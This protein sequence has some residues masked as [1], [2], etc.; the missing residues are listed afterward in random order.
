MWASTGQTT[1]GPA[2]K[3]LIRIPPNLVTNLLV[4][5][6][7]E[8]SRSVFSTKCHETIYCSVVG[9]VVVFPH[10]RIRLGASEKF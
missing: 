6:C 9:F 5:L 8:H 7:L 2:V 4:F 1:V 3:L 10:F